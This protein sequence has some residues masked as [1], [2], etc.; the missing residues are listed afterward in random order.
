[1]IPSHGPVAS[2]I[3]QA[4]KRTTDRKRRDLA[5][6][7]D[8]KEDEALARFKSPFDGTQNYYLL[9]GWIPL[10]VLEPYKLESLLPDG[11]WKLYHDFIRFFETTERTN[12][13]EFDKA[14]AK[15]IAPRQESS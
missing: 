6:T 12:K 9:E 14:V 13:D 4:P 11:T 15:R 3:G 7:D 2:T 1:L 8:E 10:R 5:M